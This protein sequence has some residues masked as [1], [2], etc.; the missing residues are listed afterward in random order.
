MSAQNG[1]AVRNEKNLEKCV[2]CRFPSHLLYQVLYVAV[3]LQ[4]P[5]NRL[6]NSDP[7]SHSRHSSLPPPSPLR[8]VPSWLSLEELSSFFPRR[9]ASNCAYGTHARR[10]P[11]SHFLHKKKMAHS[12]GLELAKS[13]LVATRLNHWTNGGA[14]L[15]RYWSHWMVTLGGHMKWSH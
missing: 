4:L 1:S 14:G 8:S 2:D 9:L 15:Q 12:A 3:L 7:G 5:I 11:A 10:F 13:A 6:R